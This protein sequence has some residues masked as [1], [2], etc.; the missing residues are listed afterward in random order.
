LISQPTQIII[1]RNLKLRRKMPRTTFYGH[2]HVQVTIQPNL[3]L[4]AAARQSIV[5]LLNLLLADETVLSL[6]TRSADE[7]TSGTV[8]PDPHSLYEAQYKQINELSA[9]IV[10]R[11]NILGGVHI[12][13]S[14][15]LIDSARLDRRLLSVPDMLGLLADHE[16]LIRFLREDAQKCSEIYEDQGTFALLVSVMRNHE[17][18]AWI[19]RSNITP[20]NFDHE[21]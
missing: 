14:E 19:L 9:E 8:F 10:E 15:R 3:G 20:G 17:K 16:A 2:S 7:E 5:E 6:K 18:M 4:D 1:I 21:K 13:D 12:S 11:I